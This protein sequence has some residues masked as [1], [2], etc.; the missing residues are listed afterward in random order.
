[1]DLT[2]GGFDTAAIVTATKAQADGD[3][4]RVEV[5]GA[6]QDRWFGTGAA[7]FNQATTKIWCNLNWSADVP[8]TLKT[9][10]AGSGAVD[11]IEVNEDIS[12]L[13]SS[14]I[15]LIDVEAFT[16]TSKSDSLK[17]LND[18]T[19]ATKGT[20]MAAHT[21]SP[22]DTVQWIQHDIWFIYDDATASAPTQDDDYEPIFD[23]A[24]ST[25]TSW[26]YAL[27]GADD[28][29]R[30]GQWKYDW[31]G[32]F[33]SAN[34]NT[35]AD[36]WEEI[37]HN[38]GA[39]YTYLYNPCGVT[40]TN[41]TNGEK[42]WGSLS[43]DYY[44]SIGSSL[45]GSSYTEEYVIPDP[46]ATDTWEAWSRNEALATGS[47]YV[48]LFLASALYSDNKVEAADCTVT[49]NSSNTPTATV[50]AEQGNYDIAAVIEN[51][52]TGESI[53]I[54]ATVQVNEDLEVDTD[55]KTVI[56]LADGSNYFSTLTV[57][58]G[59]RLHWLPLDPGNNTLQFTDAGT[60][61]VTIEIEFEKRWR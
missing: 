4:F 13:P 56:F 26:V 31:V 11:T 16:F 48:R 25:N 57:V 15:V 38:S 17:T 22:A 14:G 54:A 53:S 40:N 49:L 41:F 28:L 42:Y 12:A 32:A 51:T 3:D 7:A 21:S 9:A 10:I 39:H 46:S 27:F 20:S 34:H 44:A 23:L 8:M 47:V 1:M 60:G 58:G 2:D 33:Y 19:R 52:T 6:E 35:N 50:N 30:A 18:C 45:T 5:D 59:A 37:G 55:A 36:P 43:P 61:N 24:T 29:K